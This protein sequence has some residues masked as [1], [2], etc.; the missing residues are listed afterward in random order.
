MLKSAQS[1]PARGAWMLLMGAVFF[2]V[3]TPIAVV[4]RV[5]RRD[6]LRLAF[7][8]GKKSYWSER[9]PPGPAGDTFPRQF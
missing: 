5:L 7:E 1:A 6:L 4:L 9:Q 3:L 8:P 2:V